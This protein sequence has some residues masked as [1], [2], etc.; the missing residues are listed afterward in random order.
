[1][2]EVRLARDAMATRFEIVLFGE[3]EAFLRAVAEEALEEISRVEAQL[4]FYRVDSDVTDLNVRGA[5]ETVP[6]DPRFFRLLQTAQKLSQESEGRFDITVAPLMRAWGFVGGTGAMPEPEGIE[7]A[8]TVVGMQHVILDEA[9]FTVR[10]D[11]VGVQIDLG[12]IGKGYAVDRAVDILRENEIENALIHGG[13]STIFALGS[14][15]DAEGWTIGIQKPYSETK[16]EPIAAVTL[17][18]EALSVSAPHGKWFQSGGR[19]YG[20]VID[21]RTGQPTGKTLLAALVTPTATEG[22]ALST[23]LLVGSR[24]WLAELVQRHSEYRALLAEAGENDALVLTR[25]ENW[26]KAGK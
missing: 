5:A 21:P 25:T 22:D 17:H 13:T 4:S 2:T 20:H 16:G 1:M 24:E 15:P 18:D 8:R 9:H 12:A 7:S 6:T 10:F 3:R 23:A 11:A 14:P 26:E 19:R